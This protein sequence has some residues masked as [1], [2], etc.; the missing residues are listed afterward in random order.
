MARIDDPGHWAGILT[1]VRDFALRL[2]SPVGN[3]RKLYKYIPGVESGHRAR[4]FG[5]LVSGRLFG[6]CSTFIQLQLTTP[7]STEHHVQKQRPE[8]EHKK[9]SLNLIPTKAVVTDPRRRLSA[10]HRR[11]MLSHPSR[12]AS[13]NAS[14]STSPAR[15]SRDGDCGRSPLPL[16]PTTSKEPGIP[17]GPIEIDSPYR[18]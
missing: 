13:Q 3:A 11:N 16:K 12:Y 2:L 10:S 4:T 14:S 18:C 9:G 17:A 6:E 7:S 1:P 15:P 8:P 5:P